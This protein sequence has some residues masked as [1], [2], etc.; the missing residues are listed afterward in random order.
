MYRPPSM[1]SAHSANNLG[2]VMYDLVL[3]ERPATVVEFG[4]LH[5][6]MTTCIAQALR[7]LDAG[8]LH[9]YDLWDE[10]PF[11][12]GEMTAVQKELDDAGLAEWVTLGTGNLHHWLEAPTAFDLLFVDVANDG[13]VMRTVAEH[14]ADHVAAGALV[15]FEGGSVERDNV[16]WM[17]E[18]GREP[19]AP[20]LRNLG[21]TLLDE[22][23]SSLSILRR[24]AEAGT[25]RAGV[26][27]T[28]R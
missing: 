21:I 4:V 13:A 28:T 18:F 11:H 16:W 25:G 15:V 5:G 22:R 20:V 8:H 26:D 10:F 12:H 2:A 9:S 27:N 17:L 14:V 3:T 1:Y 7:D 23:F 24:P 19:M 6:Y